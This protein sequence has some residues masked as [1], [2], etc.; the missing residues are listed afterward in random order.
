MEDFAKVNWEDLSNETYAEEDEDFA[1]VNWDDLS[2]EDYAEDDNKVKE[3][4]ESW[5]RPEE[6]FCKEFSFNG[7]LYLRDSHDCI[8]SMKSG[9]PDNAIGLFDEEKQLIDYSFDIVVEE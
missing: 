6:G 7:V 3:E 2:K 5:I 8:W 4:P 9:N 1:K